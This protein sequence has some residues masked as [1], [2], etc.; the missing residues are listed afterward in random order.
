MS[1]F[2][3]ITVAALQNLFENVAEEVEKFLSE[4]L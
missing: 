2:E 3:A 1:D 4:I